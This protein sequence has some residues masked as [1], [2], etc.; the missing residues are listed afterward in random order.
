MCFYEPDDVEIPF[1]SPPDSQTDEA[2][3]PDTPSMDDATPSNTSQPSA[4]LTYQSKATF[5]P[6]KKSTEATPP[7]SQAF[8]F[9]VVAP[10]LQTSSSDIPDVLTS[11]QPSM[12]VGQFQQDASISNDKQSTSMRHSN[13]SKTMPS[14]AFSQ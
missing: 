10:N 1:A 14:T 3:S 12:G 5:Q 8:S 11:K 6:S 13:V 9:E 7:P 4:Q 2:S